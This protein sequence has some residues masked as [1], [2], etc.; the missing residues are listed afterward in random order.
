MNWMSILVSCIGFFMMLFLH[1]TIKNE[2][3]KMWGV[4]QIINDKL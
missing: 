4:F 3:L 1:H 2:I